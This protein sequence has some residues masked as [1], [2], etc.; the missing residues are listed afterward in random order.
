VEPATLPGPPGHAPADA[1]HATAPT[2]AT[3]GPGT[4]VEYTASN[5][6]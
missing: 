5:D 6:R 3:S 1:E 4:A 2:H